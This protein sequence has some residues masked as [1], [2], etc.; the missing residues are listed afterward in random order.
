MF[1]SCEN[2]NANDLYIPYKVDF[3]NGW[4]SAD[5]DL[6]QPYGVNWAEK[7][8]LLHHMHVL[9]VNCFIHFTNKYNGQI[10]HQ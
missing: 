2:V 3:V 4:R 1:E 5:I 6:W 10:T 8:H 7:V 9:H